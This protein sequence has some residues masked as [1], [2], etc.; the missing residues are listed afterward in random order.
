[1]AH[2][3][4]SFLRAS[5]EMVGAPPLEALTNGR[6]TLW[7]QDSTISSW[8]AACAGN[9]PA[10]KQAK[11]T[12]GV[13]L[14]ANSALP[15]AE[16]AIARFSLN[17]R[18]PTS[19]RHRPVNFGVRQKAAPLLVF[20]GCINYVTQNLRQGDGHAGDGTGRHQGQFGPRRDCLEYS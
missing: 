15:P 5:P 12:G 11:R 2:A 19:I 1:G 6:P 10:T 3:G 4:V 20:P 8:V 7:R 14:R 17:W 18:Q 9:V 16:I 13:C